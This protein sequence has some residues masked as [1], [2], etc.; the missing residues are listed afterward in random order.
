MDINEDWEIKIKEEEKQ[1]WKKLD[2]ITEKLEEDT[3][4]NDNQIENKD[5]NL[6]KFQTWTLENSK[7]KNITKENVENSLDGL[8]KTEKID[9]Q[10]KKKKEEYRKKLLARLN[11]DKPKEKEIVKE[12]YITIKIDWEEKKIK[13]AKLLGN[14]FYFTQDKE[15]TFLYFKDKLLYTIKNS[16]DF[17][18][19][20]EI[21]EN[22]DL[23]TDWPVIRAE[24]LK[25]FN[26]KKLWNNV[27]LLTQKNYEENKLFLIDTKNNKFIPLKRDFSHDIKKAELAKKWIVFLV[28][29]NYYEWWVYY[30]NRN[31]KI[32]LDI[33]KNSLNSIDN[34]SFSYKKADDFKVITDNLNNPIIEINISW[35]KWVK[36]IKHIEF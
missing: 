34:N 28:E 5:D 19:K 14:W 31:T 29:K 15:K 20:Q 26:L 11:K 10:A 17:F 30:I 23:I 22:P 33:F 4:K 25:K 6:E 27:F 3:T 24:I 13:I 32:I 1:A 7:E 12:K 2:E 16:T 35:P 8:E 36:L 18:A 9:E 21:D